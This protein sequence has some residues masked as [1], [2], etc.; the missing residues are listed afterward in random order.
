M[1]ESEVKLLSDIYFEHTA[2]LV[3]LAAHS[4]MI[5]HRQF[6]KLENQG[7]KNR[8]KGRKHEPQFVFSKRIL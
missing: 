7:K 1:T 4:R 5:P 3:R 2:I 6:T 8:K